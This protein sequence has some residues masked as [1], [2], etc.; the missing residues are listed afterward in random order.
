MRPRAGL[1]GR[2]KRQYGRMKMVGLP[3]TLVAAGLD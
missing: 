3:L 1:S 2:E